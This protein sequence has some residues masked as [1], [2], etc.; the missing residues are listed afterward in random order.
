MVRPESWS[1]LAGGSPVR[2]GTG[3]PGSRSRFVVETRRAERDVK[4]L[5]GGASTR[6][7]ASS[8]PCSLVKPTAEKPSLSCRGE[9][10]VLEA[11]FR[12][13]PPGF[14]RGIGGGTCAQ[15]GPEQER[16]V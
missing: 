12:G 10:H 8:E 1:R 11:L 14:F 13:Q 6:A 2:V 5:F 16:P 4:S 15:S 3:V 7:V 9:G